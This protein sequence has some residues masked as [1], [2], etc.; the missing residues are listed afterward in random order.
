LPDSGPS[1]PSH[2]IDAGFWQAGVR[3]AS[4]TFRFPAD[5]EDRAL[6]GLH[7][8]FVA[9]EAAEAERI[10]GLEN[11]FWNANRNQAL[12]DFIGRWRGGNAKLFGLVLAE[13][14]RRGKLTAFLDAVGGLSS[15][16]AY[17]WRDVIALAVKTRYAEHPGVLAL[18]RQAEELDRSLEKF[19][20]DVDN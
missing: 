5:L 9:A 12:W 17:R 8:P 3:G 14:D 11:T 10:L 20:Y 19:V 6:L 15:S 7:G 13:L 16:D 1:R 2:R 18:V 4:L